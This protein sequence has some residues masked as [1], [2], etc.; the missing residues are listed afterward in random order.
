MG[1]APESALI[2]A[3]ESLH[4]ID[5]ATQ[6]SAGIRQEFT[7]IASNTRVAILGYRNGNLVATVRNGVHE[8]YRL[9]RKPQPAHA[10]GGESL[11][12]ASRN[13]R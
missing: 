11:S 4:E 9:Q 6:A 12:S 8:S 13:C 5:G 7:I 1:L 10:A 3:Q 2:P